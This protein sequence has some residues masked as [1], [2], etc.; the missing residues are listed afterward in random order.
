MA[1]AR[2]GDWD[3]SNVI[4]DH[5]TYLR[6]DTR[7]DVALAGQPPRV[8]E[9][10]DVVLDDIRAIPVAGS[11]SRHGSSGLMKRRRTEET[12]LGDDGPRQHFSVVRKCGGGREEKRESGAKGEEGARASATPLLPLLIALGC[13]AE[14]TGRGDRGIN[15]AHD[16]A[17]TAQ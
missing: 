16:P 2:A 14:G 10:G 7:L 8:A 5:I 12:G 3:G 15:C 13:E 11:L 6:R 17:L 4:E 1:R 9:V